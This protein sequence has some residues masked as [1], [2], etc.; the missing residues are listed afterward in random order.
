MYYKN[1]LTYLVPFL[2]IL[3]ATVCIT[4][5]GEK[6]YLLLAQS[7]LKG[8]TSYINIP[9]LK[10]DLSYFAGKYFW[11]L[12]PFPAIITSPFVYLFGTSFQEG[13]IKFGLS[14]LNFVLIVKIATHQKLEAKKAIALA[15]FFVFGSIYTPVA[16][17]PFSS[18]FS[19][20]A[21]VTFL[22]LAIHI[23]FQKK[24]YF[25]SGLFLSLAIASRLE[26]LG[27]ILF[28]YLYLFETKN[29]LGN[30]LKFT[31]PLI[32]T[33]IV[34]ATYNYARFENPLETGQTFII[35]AKQT[36]VRKERGM[37]SPVNIAPNLY[38]MLL[39]TPELNYQNQKLTYPYIKFNKWGMSIFILSPILLMLFKSKIHDKLTKRSFLTSVLISL[40]IITFY[41]VGWEQIGYRFALNFLPFL[42]FPLIEVLKKI[43]QKIINILIYTGIAITWF[44][45][46]QFLTIIY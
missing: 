42:L 24:A 32:I 16:A 2:F 35:N 1:P 38:Y 39:K 23:F 9:D 19:Q 46:F 45:I 6:F 4:A 40:P 29:R 27:A 33:L 26:L 8:S 22:L 30:T 5:T 7:F 44:F 13:Y 14:L 28:F 34:L 21:A 3:L 18:Y 11:P 43:N 17:L 12:G 37:F 20:I 10:I 41:G 36:G 31:F 25:L 15:I